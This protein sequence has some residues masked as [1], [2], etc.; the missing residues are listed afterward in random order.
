MTE[1]F[2]CC[3]RMSLCAILQPVHFILHFIAVHCQFEVLEVSV[4]EH[5]SSCLTNKIGLSSS[6]TFP[7]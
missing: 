2:F 3:S 6:Q 5:V 7:R 1:A 4:P